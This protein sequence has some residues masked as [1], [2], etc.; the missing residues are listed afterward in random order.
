MSKAPPFG[1]AAEPE[2]DPLSVSL[3]SFCTSRKKLALRRNLERTISG[4][5]P[6]VGAGPDKPEDLPE[7]SC[8]RAGGLGAEPPTQRA[9][10]PQAYHRS[11]PFSF[12]STNFSASMPTSIMASSGSKVVK[13]CIHIPG[14]RRKRDTGPSW[15][16][17]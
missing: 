13:F 15:P 8:K 6:P 14:A 5:L 2:A 12:G 3:V 17:T 1:A 16:P 7:P 9:C 11:A 10:R 4:A